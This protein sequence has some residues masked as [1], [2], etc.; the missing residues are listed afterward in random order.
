M[1]AQDLVW[2][3]VVQPPLGEGWEKGEV[4]TFLPEEIRLLSAVCLSERDPFMK[5]ALGLQLYC[6]AEFDVEEF[7]H[8]LD[9]PELDT[10]ARTLADRL[11]RDYEAQD[12]YPTFRNAQVTLSDAGSLADAIDI[13]E[14][15]DLDDQLLLAGLS[16]LLSAL[17]LRTDGYLE[18]AFIIATI[19][20]GA[21]M[22]FVR[23]HLE[24]RDATD[25]SY[26][27][28]YDY[29][30]TVFPFGDPFPEFLEWMYD[31]RV[32]AI[33]PS[34]R[35]GEHWSPGLMV[36]MVLELENWLKIIY[37]HLLLGDVPDADP[38]RAAAAA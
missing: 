25:R 24:D 31:L 5:G 38:D 3:A 35:L 27:D 33:H 30:R 12:Y 7:P 13:L 18:E 8:K 37:R 6:R 36:G 15:I 22:E 2:C 32:I 23:L 14:A 26:K 28:V 21:A 16:R 4:G 11:R 1:A 19:S 17:R 9:D 10:Y 29:F 20:L 34:S